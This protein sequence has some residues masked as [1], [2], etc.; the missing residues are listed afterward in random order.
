V[1]LEVDGEPLVATGIP[2]EIIPGCSPQVPRVPE[3]LHVLRDH[4]VGVGTPEAVRAHT[5]LSAPPPDATAAWAIRVLDDAGLVDTVRGSPF[6]PAR[7]ALQTLEATQAWD[8]ARAAAP[9]RVLYGDEVGDGEYD[10]SLAREWLIGGIGGAAIANAEII[11]RANSS[12]H[13]SMVGTAA[14]WVLHND[15][16][17]LALRR[18]HD[19]ALG[20]DGRLTTFGGQRLGPIE[21]VDTGGG[22]RFRAGG[23][24]GDAYVACLGRVA[25]MPQALDPLMAWALHNGGTVNGELMFDRHRQ[26]LG[27]RLVFEAGG[28]RHDVVVTGAA[29]RMLPREIFSPADA[30]R[31]AALG[32]QEAPP[33]SGNVAAGFMATATQAVRLGAYLGAPRG[34]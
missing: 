12:A 6:E 13:V 34:P 29:S 17:Y 8:Q 4:L 26:Y 25:R 31:V 19:A 9:G 2:P 27:Y 16:Q 5:A 33:E 1:L 18:Q 32:D 24:E 7:L 23:V 14:P 3:A 22:A 15:A 28:E 21:V 20:G 10:P 11:L 30:S